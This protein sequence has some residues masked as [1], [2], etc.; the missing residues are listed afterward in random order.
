M[1]DAY[2]KTPKEEKFF[3]STFTI[4][5][6]NTKLQQQIEKGLSAQEI[7]ETWQKDLEKFKEIRNKYLIYK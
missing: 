1:I 3:G 5:A 4:H 2:Q 6:G 7:R